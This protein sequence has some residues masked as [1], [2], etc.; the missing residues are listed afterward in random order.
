MQCIPSSVSN[1]VIDMDAAS[2]RM[3]PW[4]SVE[5][6]S[7]NALLSHVNMSN[8]Q[9]SARIFFA[10]S[11]IPRSI[12][13]PRPSNPS[14]DSHRGANPKNNLDELVRTKRGAEGPKLKKNSPK[15]RRFG[16]QDH[17]QRL[18]LKL[19]GEP[20]VERAK[21]DPSHPFA[22]LKTELVA[23]GLE[24]FERSI[25][26]NCDT[27]RVEI[28]W[29]DEEDRFDGEKWALVAAKSHFACPFYRNDPSRHRRCLETAHLTNIFAVQRHLCRDHR[30]PAYCPVCYEIF[31][32]A[33]TRDAHIRHLACEKREVA[34]VEGVND[35]QARLIAGTSAGGVSA[36]DQWLDTFRI[37][38][39]AAET[40]SSPY[41]NGRLETRIARLREFWYQNGESIVSDYISGMWEDFRDWRCYAAIADEE[42]SLAALYEETIS[43]IIGRLIEEFHE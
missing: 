7:R 5:L 39:P 25:E 32:D 13:P 24:L 36:S 34:F 33:T 8:Q 26:K 30:Q 14:S 22:R 3:N 35:E 12:K 27:D 28:I 43:D 4:T 23:H 2:V 15:S 18:L 16:S 42:R 41:L 21:L 37:V 1:G 38:L 20:P 11:A 31:S 17:A 9:R 19:V 6:R 29:L 10:E 40:P